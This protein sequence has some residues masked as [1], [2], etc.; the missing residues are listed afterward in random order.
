MSVHNWLFLLTIIG[1][2]MGIFGSIVLSKEAIMAGL[3]ITL[4]SLFSDTFL[5]RKEGLQE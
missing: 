1:M 4:G 2:I 3:I 5:L